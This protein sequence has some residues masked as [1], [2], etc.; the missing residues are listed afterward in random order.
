[1]S[2]I[3][4]DDGS[5][6]EDRVGLLFTCYINTGEAIDNAFTKRVLNCLLLLGKSTG[7]STS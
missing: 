6:N 3:G 5:G 4:L 7:V 1:M 2:A